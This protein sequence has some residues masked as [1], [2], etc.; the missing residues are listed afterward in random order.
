MVDKVAAVFVPV[1]ITIALVT[2][3]GWLALGFGLEVALINAV[4]VLVIA[5]PCAL[6]LAT[7]AT[8][9]VGTGVAAR[10][11]ILIKDAHALE[12][13]HHLDVVVFDKTGTLTEGKP[14]LHEVLGADPDVIVAVAAAAQLGS[15]HPLADAIRDAA[16]DRKLE[17]GATTDFRALP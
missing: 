5:C 8:L 12:L 11:G 9:M 15:E 17:L 13:T 1:V 16:R 14:R 3:A 4:S 7:P 10:V 6:G 2:F